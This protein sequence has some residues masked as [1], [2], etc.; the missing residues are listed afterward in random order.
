MVAAI[1]ALLVSGPLMAWWGA[2][3]IRVLEWTIP[4]PFRMNAGFFNAAHAVHGGA[5]TVAIIGAA[6]HIGGVIKHA[7]F[8]RDGTF[9]K[10]MLAARKS[11]A[12]ATG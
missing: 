3:P 11:G 12:A 10:M 6:L 4:A 8:N 2:I 9:A 7:A 1:G 5:A